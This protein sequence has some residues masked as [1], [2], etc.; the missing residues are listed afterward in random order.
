MLSRIYP[1]PALVSSRFQLGDERAQ[2]GNLV[3]R[4]A[5]RVAARVFERNVAVETVGTQDAQERFKVHVPLAQ[6]RR[7]SPAPL[8][9]VGVQAR[10][11]RTEAR[12]AF[13]R[14]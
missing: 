9:V 13:Q 10:D 2:V 6:E 4:D 7:V 5:F 1:Q 14:V 12:G 3:A 11:V 8:P